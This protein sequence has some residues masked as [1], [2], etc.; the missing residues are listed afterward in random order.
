M[1]FD[2]RQFIKASKGLGWKDFR[3]D[4]ILKSQEL[5]IGLLGNYFEIEFCDYKGKSIRRVVLDVSDKISYSEISRALF[6]VPNVFLSES[7][8]PDDGKI[9]IIEESSNLSAENIYSAL[10]KLSSIFSEH[11]S[12]SQ[13][14][15]KP[16]I[17]PIIEESKEFSS[18][19]ELLEKSCEH[20][21]SYG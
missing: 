3:S 16:T 9:I 14:K 4:I 15:P 8:I 13:Q 21:A 11:E 12:L 20:D 2:C 17:K 7:L 1:G 19:S 6:G 5:S 18:L 10:Q